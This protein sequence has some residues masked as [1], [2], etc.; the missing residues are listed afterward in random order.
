MNRP[1]GNIED[2]DFNVGLCH[3][4]KKQQ[5][6]SYKNPHCAEFFC[7]INNVIECTECTNY[8][9]KNRKMHI[10]NPKDKDYKLKK[11][12][13]ATD[14]ECKK[15]CHD[16][17]I[18]DYVLWGS[19]G[20][21]NKTQESSVDKFKT[22]EN[23]YKTKLIT[24]Y[25]K[26]PHLLNYEYSAPKPKTVVHWGQLKMFLITLIFLMKTVEPTDERVDIIYPG[27]ARGDNILILCSMFPN[28]FWY[29]VDPNPFHPELKSHKQIMEVRNSFFTNDTAIEYKEL[30]KIRKN[31]LLL[32]S[33]IR[34]ATDDA[35]VIQNQAD[36]ISWHKII[37]PDY[38]YFK[39]RCPYDSPKMYPYY[40]GKI[41]IQPYAPSSSTESRLL[42]KKDLV[43]HVYDIDKYQAKFLYFNRLVRPCYYKTKYTIDN[44]YFD[45]CYDCTYYYFLLKK[46]LKKYE[47]FNYFSNFN[48]KN[49]SSSLS[50]S[51]I[52]MMKMITNKISK[53]TIDKIA[54]MN[55]Y[56][57]HNLNGTK[58]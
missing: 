12:K 8:L 55:S 13:E 42:L 38:S 49:D 35:S 9:I 21:I 46:Y 44:N 19:M 3:L 52:K 1:D 10:H 45:H 29:L 54:Y 43:E 4:N 11:I 7:T 53:K 24:T 17:F 48:K 37:Q 22:M 31:K 16:G 26:I 5:N 14:A 27:S 6:I 57:R 51:T 34:T 58:K 18:Y 41:Y 32:I 33:D 39:F 15:K 36:N 40:K 2:K 30:F 20:K 25:N 50:D 47:K 56:I 23:F 28:T